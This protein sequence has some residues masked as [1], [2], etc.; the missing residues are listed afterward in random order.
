MRTGLKVT[1]IWHD[2]DVIELRV[3]VENAGFRGTA[4]VYVGTDE[5]TNA[6]TALAGFPIDSG[7]KREVLLGA[8]GKQSAGGA[9]CLQFYCSDSVGHAAFR[10][11]IE[12]DY[13]RM[14]VAESATVCVEFEPAALDEFIVQLQRVG[15]EYQGSA[16]LLTVP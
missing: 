1:C 4:D 2:G 11:R 3:V 15:T 9:V 16:S 8:E 10:A 5:L 6:A 7:D 12:G 14:E 13:G